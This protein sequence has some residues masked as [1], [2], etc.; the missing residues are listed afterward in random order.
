[1]TVIDIIQRLEEL[2]PDTKIRIFDAFGQMFTPIP[3]VD[4]WRGS[5]YM[6]AVVVKP[7]INTNMCTTAEE[8]IY[9]LKSCDG[10]EVTGWKGGDFVLSEDSTLFLV[11]KWGTA[12][13]AT[14]IS[15]ILSDGYCYI[16]E[17][18]Y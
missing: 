2:E 9:A 14:T 12:G 3:D 4:S 5:Y 13:N 16:Q 7:I 6:P 1:M 8:F 17:D 18:S 15:K 10:L 11:S